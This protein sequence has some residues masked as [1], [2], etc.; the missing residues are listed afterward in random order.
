MEKEQCVDWI[1]RNEHDFDARLVNH[2]MF[3]KTTPLI[4]LSAIGNTRTS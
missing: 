4:F 1:M 2:S 3:N